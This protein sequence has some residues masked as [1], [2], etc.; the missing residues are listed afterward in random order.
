M[1]RVNDFIWVNPNPSAITMTDDDDVL[2]A[3][4]YHHTKGVFIAYLVD[5]VT[6][7][8]RVNCFHLDLF[9]YGLNF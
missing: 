1:V 2:T 8:E 7:D 6:S 4:P 5:L 3:E 9:F